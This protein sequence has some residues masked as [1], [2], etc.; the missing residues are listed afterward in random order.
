MMLAADFIKN[1]LSPDSNPSPSRRPFL[2]T[3]IGDNPERRMVWLNAA[4]TPWESQPPIAIAKK[5]LPAPAAVVKEGLKV[6]NNTTSIVAKSF[7]QAEAIRD[8]VNNVGDWD[9]G[10]VGIFLRNL[11]SEWMCPVAC[12]LVLEVIKREDGVGEDGMLYP[13]NSYAILQKKKK[14]HGY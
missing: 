7:V 12:S 9:R 13:A 8:A 2:Q 3:L 14:R 4:L 10:R 6:N 1:N 11:G 5:Y